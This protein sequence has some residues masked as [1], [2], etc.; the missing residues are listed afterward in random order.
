MVAC[1]DVRGREA[2]AR[3]ALASDALSLLLA[4][5]AVGILI[6]TYSSI[7]IAAAQ[8]LYLNLR[9]LPDTQG[10]GEPVGQG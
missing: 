9:P 2:R 7:F 3:N 8:L 1:A 4:L 6:G 5:Y 10:A